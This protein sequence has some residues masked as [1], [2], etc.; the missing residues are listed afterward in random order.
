VS[1]PLKHPQQRTR[2][3]ALLFIAARRARVC[4]LFR[5][6]QALEP[7]IG[8]LHGLAVVSEPVASGP[9]TPVEELLEQYR[10]YLLV[11]RALT[12]G[13]AGVYVEAIRPFVAS[14]EGAERVEL[15]RVTAAD[16]SAFVLQAKTGDAG[17]NRTYCGQQMSDLLASTG[18][19]AGL[20]EGRPITGTSC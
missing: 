3:S 20:A 7:M 10:R 9:L 19:L 1:D 5:S 6:R 15:E 12:V 18:A 11:E 2:G 4:R 13:T 16:V 17:A 14:F 8:Y